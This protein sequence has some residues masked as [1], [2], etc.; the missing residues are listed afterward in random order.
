[1]PKVGEL[2]GQA[3][4]T[5][6][7]LGQDAW[8]LTEVWEG[9]CTEQGGLV[10][11]QDTEDEAPG[12]VQVR[13][14]LEVKAVGQAVHAAH[15]GCCLV[16]RAE[17]WGTVSCWLHGGQELLTLGPDSGSQAVVLCNQRS[18]CCQ[19]PRIQHNGTCDCL[20]KDLRAQ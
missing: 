13:L 18:A 3:S 8:K 5:G 16:G 9:C 10:R 15:D 1:M 11:G 17:L 6:Q 4:S 14:L 19:L 7:H 12:Q 20:L 2:S